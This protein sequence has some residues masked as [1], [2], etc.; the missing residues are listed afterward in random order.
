MTKYCPCGLRRSIDPLQD[1]HC[2]FCGRRLQFLEAELHSPAF[3]DP[4]VKSIPIDLSLCNIGPEQFRLEALDWLDGEFHATEAFPFRSPHELGPRK[5]VR[6]RLMLP[7]PVQPGGHSWRLLFRTN[8]PQLYPLIIELFPPRLSVSLHPNSVVEDREG[9]M[10]RFALRVHN[11]GGDAVRL[12][13]LDWLNAAGQTAPALSFPEQLKLEPA[14][15]IESLPCELMLPNRDDQTR[16][17]IVRLRA[18]PPLWDPC[19][20]ELCIPHIPVS[21]TCPGQNQIGRQAA[22]P[23]I[24]KSKRP[25]RMV[26]KASPGRRSLTMLLLLLLVG[27]A[28]W[29]ILNQHSWNRLPEVEFVAGPAEGSF[30]HEAT[31]KIAWKVRDAAPVRGFLFGHNESDPRQTVSLPTSMV[32]LTQPG[33][34][35]VTVIPLD[36]QGRRGNP[37]IRTFIFKVNQAP[38]LSVHI[39]REKDGQWLRDRLQ[40]V[41]K[42]PQGERVTLQGQIDGSSWQPIAGNAWDWY[43]NLQ[44]EGRFSLVLRARND[45][46]MTTVAQYTVEQYRL[47]K[48]EWIK[49]PTE[50]Q[51]LRSPKVDL[52]WRTRN[53][54]Q[55]TGYLVRLNEIELPRRIV[56]TTMKLELIRPGMQSI[57]ITPLLAGDFQGPPLGGSFNY[58]PNHAP[59]LVANLMPSSIHAGESAKL[60]VIVSDPDTDPVNVEMRV[61]LAPWRPCL[62]LPTQSIGE[63]LLPGSHRITLKA[64]DGQGAESLEWTGDLLVEPVA[65]PTPTPTLTPDPTPTPTLRP[66][67]TPKTRTIK[68]SLTSLPRP[69]PTPRI[70]TTFATMLSARQKTN[71]ARAVFL[72]LKYPGVD[73]QRNPIYKAAEELC[74]YAKAA[75]A[76]RNYSGAVSYYNK[77][78]ETYVQAQNDLRK[79]YGSGDPGF[80]IK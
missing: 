37:S 62:T 25:T 65:T 32:S 14:A 53:G 29:L 55:V 79:K 21:D 51:V 45:S 80:S 3:F 66:R 11:I 48:L 19:D 75:E 24:N 52:Q 30:V 4:A 28:T 22:K 6:L 64:N 44:T 57:M 18:E 7:L 15:S 68:P 34:Q 69:T 13:G 54:S 5:K 12:I 17:L 50:D 10:L 71:V 33:L 46:G 74:A 41:G 73:N 78:R 61:D 43:R 8:P 76:N 2:G 77:A 47:P 31:V 1:R 9:R 27:G 36:K 67:S 16:P 35:T 63:D 60:A 40:V 56:G 23:L 26:P 58:V 39:T 49:R 38:Q 20:I 59:Q 42:D 70:E 72:S